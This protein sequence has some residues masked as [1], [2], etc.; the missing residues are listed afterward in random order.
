MP[1]HYFS[2]WFISSP[3]QSHF[4]MISVSVS[5]QHLG[6]AVLSLDSPSQIY[7]CWLTR[8]WTSTE[9]ETPT[10][11][12]I[13]LQDCQC[14]TDFYSLTCSWSDSSICYDWLILTWS[15]R[16]TST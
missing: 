15:Q 11:C 4:V 16:P 1:P 2:Q 3:K 10:D 8:F 6:S 14:L 12:L 5:L 9:I 13:L 7:Y